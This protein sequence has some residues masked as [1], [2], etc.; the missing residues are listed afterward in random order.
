MKR[1][2]ATLIAAQMA[3]GLGTLG[4]GALMAQTF[5]VSHTGARTVETQ[6]WIEEWDPVQ[7]RW[8]KVADDAAGDQADALPTVVTTIVN[9][10]AVSQTRSAARYAQPVPAKRPEMALAQYGPFLVTSPDVARMVG[11][12]NGLSPQHFDA[13]LRDFPGIKTLEMVEAPGTSND[14]AN[15]AVGRKIREAG[16]STHVPRGGSVRSGAVELFLAGHTRSIDEGATFAVHSWLDNH[17]READ[18]FAADHPAH[19]LYLDYYVEMGMSS[20]QAR[21]FY[22]MTNS[23]PHASAR[24]LKADEMRG[25]IKPELQSPQR[26]AARVLE[27]DEGEAVCDFCERVRD[28]LSATDAQIAAMDFGQLTFVNAQ[29]VIDYSDVTGVKIAFTDTSLLDS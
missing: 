5:D 13:M 18:D 12:T 10:R 3:L 2:A 20:R 27:A 17:G 26:Y 29:P 9:G 14:I 8:V 16:I 1:I 23:V 15:L 4:S 25:W 21:E 28:N 19:R 11:S 22:A 7:G 24:W 6:S